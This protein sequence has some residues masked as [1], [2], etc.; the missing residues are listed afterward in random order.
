[1]TT[2]KLNIEL[3]NN[4]PC[5]TKQLTIGSDKCIPDL[6]NEIKQLYN[7]KEY[8]YSVFRK[9]YYLSWMYGAIPFSCF[10]IKDNDIINVYPKDDVYQFRL[11]YGIKTFYFPIHKIIYIIR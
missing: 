4:L 9:G 8:D 5:I 6:L 1:M 10:H 2:I 7:I 3:Y 11:H